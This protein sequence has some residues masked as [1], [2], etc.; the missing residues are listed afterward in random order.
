MT[1]YDCRCARHRPPVTTLRP[2]ERYVD[3]DPASDPVSTTIDVCASWMAERERQ[4]AAQEKR[5]RIRT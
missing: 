3:V 1:R 5:Q 2:S 4:R